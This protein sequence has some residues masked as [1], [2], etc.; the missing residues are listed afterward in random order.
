MSIYENPEIISDKRVVDEMVCPVTVDEMF[1]T[2]PEAFRMM[3]EAA[4]H[5]LNK[6]NENGNLRLLSKR[7]ITVDKISAACS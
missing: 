6:L 3:L 7:E 2:S 1:S 5:R 4:I